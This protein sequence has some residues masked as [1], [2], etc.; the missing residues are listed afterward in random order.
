MGTKDQTEAYA[1]GFKQMTR[2][3]NRNKKNLQ[4]QVQQNQPQHHPNPQCKDQHEHA[5]KIIDAI[6]LDINTSNKE[7]F[8]KSNVISGQANQTI[9]TLNNTPPLNNQQL[10]NMPTSSRSTDN[11]TSK[12]INREP[13]DDNRAPVEDNGTKIVQNGDKVHT[14]QKPADPPDQILTKSPLL[15]I[16]SNSLLNNNEVVEDSECDDNELHESELDGSVSEYETENNSTSENDYASMDE[17]SATSDDLADTLMETFN[18]QLPPPAEM[19]QAFGDI[20]EKHNLSPRGSYHSRGGM[21]TRT[22]R[23]GKGINNKYTV[24]YSQDQNNL[25]PTF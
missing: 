13:M 3:R 2:R 6:Q 16:N 11:I 12:K 23:R 24:S 9:K 5:S 10:Q 19:V 18:Q 22:S 7:K 17:K 15:D 4:W 8:Q 25:S 20:T 21:T 1:D 14:P